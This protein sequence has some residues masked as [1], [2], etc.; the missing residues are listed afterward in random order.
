MN[1]RGKI[2]VCGGHD[3]FLKSLKKILGKEVRYVDREK[4]FPIEVLHD[5]SE[6]WIQVNSMSHKSYYKINT[7]AR[8][9]K[10]PIGYL[11]YA[12]AQKC[13]DQIR[14]GIH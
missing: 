14:E 13:A 2:I 3:T 5:A 12:S 1:D 10:I 8:K 4:N 6:I 9:H 7:Y 11:Q